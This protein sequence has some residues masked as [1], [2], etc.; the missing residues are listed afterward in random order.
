MFQ[1]SVIHY[2]IGKTLVEYVLS[3][4]CSTDDLEKM[5]CKLREGEGSTYFITVQNILQRV[6]IRK[7]RL[8]LKLGIDVDDLNL[9]DGTLV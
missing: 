7:A 2:S 6:R 8:S 4:K 9:D 5:F 1:C 3:G